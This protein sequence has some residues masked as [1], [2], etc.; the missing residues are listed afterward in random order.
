[1][2]SKTFFKNDKRKK[3]KQIW[4][5]DRNL[6]LDD[7]NGVSTILVSIFFMSQFFNNKTIF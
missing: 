1:M 5:N 6:N 3:T 4:Q 7:R 2:R